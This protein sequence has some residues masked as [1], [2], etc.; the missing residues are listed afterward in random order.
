MAQPTVTISDFAPV[1][2]GTARSANDGG[3]APPWLA[4]FTDEQRAQMTAWPAV[5]WPD[6]QVTKRMW[7]HIVMTGSGH[8]MA[9]FRTLDECLDYC[10]AMELAPVGLFVCGRAI[11]ASAPL[12]PP[13][14]SDANQMVLFDDGAGV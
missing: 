13:P 8:R 14:P 9:V 6:C 4:Y 3:D 12:T 11:L 5:I 10:E 2:H 1:D 7:R